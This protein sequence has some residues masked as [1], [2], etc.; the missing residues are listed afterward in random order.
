[1]KRTTVFLDSE[2]I[3]RARRFARKEGKSFAQVVREAVAKYIVEEPPAGTPVPGIAG[4]FASG[5]SDVSARVDELLWQD[6]HG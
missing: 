1:M 4:K 5:R 3:R 2:L 6:P